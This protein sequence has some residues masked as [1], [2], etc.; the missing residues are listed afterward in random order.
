MLLSGV[1]ARTVR[2]IDNGTVLRRPCQQRAFI[3]STRWLEERQE[4][5]SSQAIDEECLS[6]AAPR[7]HHT[8]R[9][10][11]TLVTLIAPGGYAAPDRFLIVNVF[12]QV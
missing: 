11:A 9:D 12:F 2:Q 7:R 3:R 10:R 1:S 5:L 4:G 6:R 8:L